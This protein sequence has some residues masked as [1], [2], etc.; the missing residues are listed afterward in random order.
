MSSIRVL[1]WQKFICYTSAHEFGNIFK[2]MDGETGI[3][4]EIVL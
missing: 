3:L 2:N 1:A 4:L